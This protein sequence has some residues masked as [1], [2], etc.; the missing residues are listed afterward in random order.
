LQHQVRSGAQLPDK[1]TLALRTVLFQRAPTNNMLLPRFSLRTILVGLTPCAIFSLAL[2]QAVQGEPWAIVVSVAV[3]SLLLLLVFH[4]LL[5]LLSAALA[6]LVGTQA[7]SA[8]TSRGGVQIDSQHHTI[9][10][11]DTSPGQH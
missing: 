10:G 4:G 1:T 6:R 5:Y 3:A 11:P 7:L 9:P 2:G 8:R